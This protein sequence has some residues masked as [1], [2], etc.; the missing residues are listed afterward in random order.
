MT[1][2]SGPNRRAVLGA[3]VGFAALMTGCV[4]RDRL[5]V[6]R[7][8]FSDLDRWADADH[9]AALRVFASTQALARPSSSLNVAARDWAAVDPDR[10]AMIVPL[11]Q[12]PR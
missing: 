9:D 11:P 4:L 6:E 1:L 5:R 3:G 8:T 2:G 7:L 12:R 10:P